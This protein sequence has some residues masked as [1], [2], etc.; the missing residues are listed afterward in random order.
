MAFPAQHVL[1]SVTH[2]ADGTPGRPTAGPG[3]VRACLFCRGLAASARCFLGPGFWAAELQNLLTNRERP[4]VS[5]AAT[6]DSG[7]AVCVCR[8]LCR[9]P[10][11]FCEAA[12]LAHQSCP[13]LKSPEHQAPSTG[14]RGS[15]VPSQVPPSTKSI[16][17]SDNKL[18]SVPPHCWVSSD[19]PVGTSPRSWHLCRPSLGVGC[20]YRETDLQP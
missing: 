5:P 15:D 14:S 12:H 9:G 2:S 17:H 18:S 1:L 7:S 13:H 19:C 10:C 11:L 4:G 20:V 16:A 3:H 6:S 8:S